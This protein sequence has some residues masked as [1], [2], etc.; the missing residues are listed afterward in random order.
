VKLDQ[1]RGRSK[2]NSPK[3][4]F[5]VFKISID[6]FHQIGRALFM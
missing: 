3:V 1:H 6:K 2:L 5:G 4:S